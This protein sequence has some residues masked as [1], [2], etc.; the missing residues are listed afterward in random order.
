MRNPF[1]TY[2]LSINRILLRLRQYRYP[3]VEPPHGPPPP[4]GRRM[5]RAADRPPPPHPLYRVDR[6]RHRRRRRCGHSSRPGKIR[7]GFSRTEK[8]QSFNGN[9]NFS[10]YA[11][12]GRNFFHVA[13]RT[14][15]N[16]SD[17]M[18]N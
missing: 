2:V 5:E 17:S 1:D 9:S 15:E 8:L 16:F 12:I 10:N 6:P 13:S 11:K 14:E 7:S 3:I 4:G 18:E